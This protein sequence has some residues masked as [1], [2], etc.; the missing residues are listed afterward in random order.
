[1]LIE[2]PQN[3]VEGGKKEASGFGFSFETKSDASF[4]DST[5][6]EY[7]KICWLKWLNCSSAGADDGFNYKKKKSLILEQ[8]EQLWACFTPS[9]N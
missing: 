7:L 3:S 1:M 9:I 4:F 2:I 5:Q 6:R 8:F